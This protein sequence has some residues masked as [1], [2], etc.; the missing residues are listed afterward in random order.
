[1]T[2]TSPLMV[3]D[4]LPPRQA[5]DEHKD[6]KIDGSR[7]QSDDARGAPRPVH[8]AS[9]RQ[10][11]GEGEP[12]KPNPLRY[13]RRP[14]EP[15]QRSPVH[16]TK[17]TATP[18][19]PAQ[20]ED[21]R[22][23]DKRRSDRTAIPPPDNGNDTPERT[24]PTDE[25]HRAETR[26]PQQTEHEATANGHRSDQTDDANARHKPT[27]KTT[28]SRANERRNTHQDTATEDT[29]RNRTKDRD[30]RRTGHETAERKQAQE[31]TQQGD[32]AHTTTQPHNAHNKRQRTEARGGNKQR[33]QATQT[34]PRHQKHQKHQHGEKPKNKS[35]KDGSWRQTV[36]REKV[37]SSETTVRARSTRTTTEEAR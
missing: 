28:A 5:T 37:A 18:L 11:N 33:R 9:G 8:H 1:M 29:R 34:P 17:A 26:K 24:E 31:T 3:A 2:P 13:S 10:Q 30:T 19:H 6:T 25:T 32:R 22:G 7:R 36:E 27:A 12:A 15:P 4:W 21:S 35:K 23:R 20:M 16:D 14:K